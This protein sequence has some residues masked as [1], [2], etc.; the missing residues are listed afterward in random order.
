MTNHEHLLEPGTPASKQ[1]QP[2]DGPLPLPLDFEAYYLGHQEFFHST[3]PEG[4]QVQALADGDLRGTH[5]P[6]QLTPSRVF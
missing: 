6:Q 1:P 3:G 4:Y 2:L 5:R